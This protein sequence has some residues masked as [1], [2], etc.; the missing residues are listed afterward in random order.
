MPCSSNNFFALLSDLTLKPNI[1]APVVMAR[2]TSDSVIPPTPE[3][4]ISTSTSS[5]PIF[6]KDVFI[7]SLVPATSDLTII[8]NLLI[9]S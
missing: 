4:T 1:L 7:A 8:L 3:L 6:N 2:F 5:L 9:F